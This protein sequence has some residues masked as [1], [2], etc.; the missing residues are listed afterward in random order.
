MKESNCSYQY[1]VTL[2]VFETQDSRGIAAGFTCAAA[3][4]TLVIHTTA[5]TVASGGNE[6]W[7]PALVTGA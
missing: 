2:S 5:A 3:S 1:L 7:A 6:G 4:V